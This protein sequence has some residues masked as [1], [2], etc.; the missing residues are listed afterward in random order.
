M[1]VFRTR[2]LKRDFDDIRKFRITYE[3][4]KKT[5]KQ[6]Y[7]ESYRYFN[8]S[9][10]LSKPSLGEQI[11]KALTPRPPRLFNVC[12]K[13]EREVESREKERGGRKERWQ[14]RG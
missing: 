11:I 7:A 1:F 13:R 2:L 8:F 3:E 12:I 9:Y 10:K 6:K 5:A 14:A 4:K